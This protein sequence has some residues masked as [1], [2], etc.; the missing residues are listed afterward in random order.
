MFDEN[1]AIVLSELAATAADCG[2]DGLSLMILLP[3]FFSHTMV[4][5]GL[6]MYYIVRERSENRNGGLTSET[7]VETC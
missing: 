3:E 6:L 2:C 4:K 5:R 1:G 7:R